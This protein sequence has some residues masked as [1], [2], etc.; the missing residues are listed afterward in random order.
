MHPRT[1][2]E[3]MRIINRPSSR[4]LFRRLLQIVGGMA[5]C[6]LA[7]TARGNTVDVGALSYDTFVPA[8]IGSPG[9][10][11]FDLSNLTG[12]FSLPPDFPVI[13]SLTF[14]SAKLILTLSD[15]S[16]K[17]FILG[18]I[19]PGFLLDLSGNPIVQVPGDEA[20]VSAEFTATL[21]PL[22]FTLSGGKS[23][24]AGSGSIDALLLPSSGSTLTVDL[25]QTAIAI[26]SPALTVPEPSAGYLLASGLLLLAWNLQR[27]RSSSS[28][29]G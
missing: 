14:G 8:G 5:F 23:F 2:E 21:S 9:I 27:R 1:Q 25:D 28:L 24:N 12:A 16:H 29:R 26:S 19:G 10:D 15:L 20:F 11:A 6:L 4:A 7:A 22:I 18:A 13:D 17:T 3:F